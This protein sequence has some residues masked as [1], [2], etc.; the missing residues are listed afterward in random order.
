MPGSPH[1]DGV[2]IDGGSHNITLANSTIENNHDQ[3]S[4]VMIDNGF[5][6]C[7]NIVV[8]GNRLV[9]GGYTVYSDGQFNGGSIT[10]ISFVNNRLGKGSYGYAS[11]NQ[12]TPTWTGNVDDAT[13][14]AIPSYK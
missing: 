7:S 3:T 13:G 9:G 8:S 10:G 11:V 5:G 2:Q 1:Y 14:T 4:S 6:P 12:N